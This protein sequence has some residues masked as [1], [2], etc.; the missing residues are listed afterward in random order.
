VNRRDTEQVRPSRRKVGSV[1]VLAGEAGTRGGAAKSTLLLCEELTGLATSVTLF[2]T[3]RPDDAASERLKR[4]G[5]RVVTPLVAKGWRFD[6]PQMSLVLQLE[7][8]VR[9]SRPDFVHCVS[10]SPEAG[11]LLRRQ[12]NVPI[13]IWETTEALPRSKFVKVALGPRLRHARA[14]FTPSASISANFRTTYTYDGEIRLLPFWTERSGQPAAESGDHRSEVFLYIGRID[15]DKGLAILAEAFSDV[16]QSHPSAELKIFGG[17]DSALVAKIKSIDPDIAADNLIDEP[18]LSQEL[19]SA[20]ALV[21]PSFHEGY[22]LSLLEACR[23]GCPII[24]TDVGSVGEVFA[25]KSFAEIIPAGDKNRLVTAMNSILG[26]SDAQDAAKRLDARDFFAAIN[27][28]EV[29]RRSLE[30]A[31]AI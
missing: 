23:A 14:V 21:L 8:F 19:A 2:V 30:E 18:R 11:F 28:P 24:A 17:G 15:A 20:A 25:G 26:C 1:A 29:I 27:S 22:P 6:I 3:T 10:L 16:K 13:Y 12:S 7:A 4:A 31:Y 9:S 5:V